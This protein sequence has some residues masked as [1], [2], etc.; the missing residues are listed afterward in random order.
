MGF[1]ENL[2]G[3]YPALGFASAEVKHLGI[4]VKAQATVHPDEVMA[5]E[6]GSDDAL[7]TG[8]RYHWGR[9]GASRRK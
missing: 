5:R 3:S 9:P 8:Y 1:R 4:V 6:W 2:H 7:R